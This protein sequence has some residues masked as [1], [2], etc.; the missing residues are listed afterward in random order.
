[1]IFWCLLTEH[2]FNYVSTYVKRYMIM[3]Y[4]Y[5]DR[6]GVMRSDFEI[7]LDS[8]GM[9]FAAIILGWSINYLVFLDEKQRLANPFFISWLNIDCIILM[10]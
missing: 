5:P 3:K 9:V 10:I 6:R 4:G 8:F 2:I 1:M 7:Q